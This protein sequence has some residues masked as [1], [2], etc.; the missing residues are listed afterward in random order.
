MQQC[1][2]VNQVGVEVQVV[3]E[4]YAALVG[5]GS[6]SQG[7]GREA[8]EKK[9]NNTHESGYP[10]NGALA[11]PVVHGVGNRTGGAPGLHRMTAMT[12]KPYNTVVARMGTSESRVSS[13]APPSP[14]ISTR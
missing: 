6:R 12:V 5:T 7:G 14:F 11:V 4:V 3:Y 10:V 13:G 2:L 1:A 8:G 9:Q